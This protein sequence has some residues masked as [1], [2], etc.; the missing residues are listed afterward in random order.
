LD[1]L[2]KRVEQRITFIHVDSHRN[3]SAMVSQTF[4]PTAGASN[5]VTPIIEG[6]TIEDVA[7][8]PGV[9]A[10]EIADGFL[11]EDV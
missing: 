6:F 9:T 11:I 4:T 5:I 2:T 10:K 7:F 8:V 1:G 3:E